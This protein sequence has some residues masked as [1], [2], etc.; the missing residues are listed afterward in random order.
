MILDTQVNFCY[1]QINSSYPYNNKTKSII[2][3][4]LRLGL[5]IILT[6]IVEPYRSTKAHTN[7]VYT[8]ISNLVTKAFP[9]KLETS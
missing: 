9:A 4:L 3:V 8:Q 2:R 7:K 6:F 5:V 1:F